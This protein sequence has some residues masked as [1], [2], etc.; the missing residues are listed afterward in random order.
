[1]AV[2]QPVDYFEKAELMLKTDPS[3][4]IYYAN[5]ALVEAR[6][7]GDQGLIA[8]GMATLGQAYM[9]QGDYDMAFETIYS[10]MEICPEENSL[11]L[12][13]IYVRLCGCYIY[14]KDFDKAFE[15][16]D[17]AADM[18]D[19]AGDRENLAVCYNSRGLIY[20]QV[21]DNKKAEE[22]LKIALQI[23]RELGKHKQV[24]ANLNNLCLYEGDTEEK[25]AMLYEAIHIN[26]SLN[27]VWSLGENYNNLGVQ[28]Y[29]GKAYPKALQALETALVY[30]VPINAKEII[31]D[32]YLYKSWVYSAVGNYEE[33]Y[34]N[35]LNLYDIEH[36]FSQT[37][38]L[39]Q[40]EMNIIRKNI[41][42]K[43]QTLI[44][45]QQAF[46]IKRLRMQ[47]YIAFLVVVVVTLFLIYTWYHFRQQK[48]IQQ[49]ETTRKIDEQEK[50]LI[51]KELNHNRN[52]LTNFAFFVRSRNE[53]LT[54]IQ[55]MV[56]QGYK[57]KEDEREK[58][59][60]KINAYISQF[61]AKN[62][63]TEVLIDQISA[64]FMER[65][66]KLHP[67]LSR[68]EKRLASLLKIDLTTKEIASIIDSTPKTVNMARYRLRKRM[69]LENDE[70]LTE[71]IKSI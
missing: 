18:Y 9:N 58:H 31:N 34:K 14:M 50:E 11:V 21:P 7:A 70:S 41:E 24:A 28:Y 49:L 36:E 57:M 30:A 26:D 10:A 17:K 51:E 55:T 46:Q 62:T 2:A 23:N 69:N 71:Y 25:I 1:M 45:Q 59:L 63:E 68:N 61:N 33:A 37:A 54:N 3:R 42:S 29:Y 52:E 8:M 56:R 15:Y 48:K 27:V 66:S 32:N 16:I 40:M 44:L 38:E 67:D 65:L 5:L 35:L 4:S 53:L 60:R 20:I 39:R 47:G 43:E 22:N 64:D 13:N 19:K 12:A 6:K